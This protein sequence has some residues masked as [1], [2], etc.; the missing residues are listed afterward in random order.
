MYHSFCFSSSIKGNPIV[1]FRDLTKNKIKRKHNTAYTAFIAICVE[2]NELSCPIKFQPLL[3]KCV[4]V[5]TKDGN[6]SI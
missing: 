3:R 6:V 4:N 5:F 2:S 1:S